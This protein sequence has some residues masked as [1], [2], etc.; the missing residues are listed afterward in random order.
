M[1][2]L[3]HLPLKPTRFQIQ[4]YAKNWCLYLN[5]ISYR[6]SPCPHLFGINAA[7]I[8]GY[9]CL[10]SFCSPVWYWSVYQVSLCTYY[11]RTNIIM[12]ECSLCLG[13]VFTQ[14]MNRCRCT[15]MNRWLDVISHIW[16][17]TR[18]NTN[19]DGEWQ[20]GCLINIY[21]VS[22]HLHID[23]LQLSVMG[24]LLPRVGAK[25]RAVS[26]ET[27]ATFTGEFHQEGRG[28]LSK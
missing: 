21:T 23:N 27:A 28:M 5:L 15:Q 14:P 26:R 13:H 10:Y 11:P 2:T 9:K 8:H 25:A 20:A 12:G 17:I 22:L 7:I 16:T 24:R 6:N 1:Q 18:Q 19:Y 3:Y 4:P